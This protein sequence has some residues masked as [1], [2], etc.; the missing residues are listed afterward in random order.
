[1]SLSQIVC[2]SNLFRDAIELHTK[3]GKFF[4]RFYIKMSSLLVEIMI[5]NLYSDWS[6]TVVFEWIIESLYWFTIKKIVYCKNL[7]MDI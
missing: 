6:E 5:R 4:E 7:V 2:T 3:Q 1:M